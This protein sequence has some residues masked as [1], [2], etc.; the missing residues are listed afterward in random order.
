MS[1]GS[2]ITAGIWVVCG[3][4]GRAALNDGRPM[5]ALHWAGTMGR[6]RFI[7]VKKS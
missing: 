4:P 2:I 7:G 5:Y 6:E 3:L 1:I